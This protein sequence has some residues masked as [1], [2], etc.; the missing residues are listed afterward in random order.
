[1]TRSL[2]PKVVVLGMMSKIPVSGVVWQTL[3]YLVGLDRLGIDAYYVEAHAR[4]PSML[5]TDASDDSSA[6]AAGFVDKVLSR[7]GLGERW[8]FQALHDDGR[9]FGMDASQLSALYRDAALIIN[10]HGGTLPL[11]EHVATGRLVYLETDP[12]QPQIELFDGD[13]TTA[14][15]LDQHAVHFTFAENLGSPTCTLPWSDRYDFL[16]TRQPVVL[17]WWDGG[18]TPPGDRFTTIANWH[19]PWRTVRFGDRDLGWS[20]DAQYR[21][22]LDLPSRSPARLEL[23]LAN[24]GEP[25][26]LLL[27]GQGWH[28]RSAAALSDDLDAYREYIQGSRGEFSVAKEQNVVFR[29]GWFSDRSATYLASGRPVI[30]QDTGF[31]EVLPTGS[32]LLAFSSVEEAFLTFTVILSTLVLQGLSLPVLIKK[33]DMK[34]DEGV[35]YEETRARLQ[36]SQAGLARL[37]E[38]AK[39]ETLPEEVVAD[40]REHLT[41]RTERFEARTQGSADA[42]YETR[43]AVY[44]RLR[45]EV[46]DAERRTVV[47]LRDQS[48]ISDELMQRLQRTLDLEEQRLETEEDNF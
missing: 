25:D 16:P 27:E 26:R 6:L 32:G 4:T 36:T 48:A 41:N 21:P 38:I 13:A 17:D 9:C 31:G 8:A 28:V 2:R 23:A 5:M 35:A 46:V 10:L 15:F 18:P 42:G 44:R 47:S 34:E 29:T 1:M 20:K 43:A 14:D 39:S 19:Q 40:L 24:C 45:R 12:V 22:L 37:E 30:M 3:H 33:L 7:F 11:P